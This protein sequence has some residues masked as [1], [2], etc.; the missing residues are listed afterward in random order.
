MP[1]TSADPISYTAKIVA[2]K[3]AIEQSLPQPLFDDPYAAAL[4]GDEVEHLLA[5]WQQVSAQ[6]GRALEEVIAKRTRYIAIRTRFFDDLLLATLPRLLEPQVVILGSGLDTRAYRLPWPPATCLYEVDVPAVLDYKAN[7]L[8]NHEANCRH[9]LIAG[10]LGDVQTG[11]V[12][13]LLEAGLKQLP[14]IWL[15]E[16]VMMYLPE[17]SAHSLLKTVATLSC[18]GSVLGMDGVNDGSIQAAQRAKQDDRGRVVRHWQFGCDDPQQL[19]K[20]YGWSGRVSQ[21]QDVGI[22][23]SRYPESMP[24]TAEVGDHQS[25][26]GVWLMQA[27]KDP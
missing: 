5:K 22:A 16:G 23:H 14:T 1:P 18:P 7:I 27:K 4:A 3:R 25:E 11:W 24:V 10:D 19:L 17:P 9:H 13:R 26:R 20:R 12:A 15:L 6:Q 2:A 8:R 21:P